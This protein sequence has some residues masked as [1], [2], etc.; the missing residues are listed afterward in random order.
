MS[1]IEKE[2]K[3]KHNIQDDRELERKVHQMKIKETVDEH[4][5]LVV[6]LK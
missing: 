5:R 3:A 4:L 2:M 6:H 1:Q